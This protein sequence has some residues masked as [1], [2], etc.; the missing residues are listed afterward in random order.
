LKLSEI[1]QQKRDHEVDLS[2]LDASQ[3]SW[4][5]MMDKVRKERNKIVKTMTTLEKRYT[6]QKTEMERD[7]RKK[8]EESQKMINELKTQNESLKKKLE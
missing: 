2:L 7:H 5:T 3:S 1:E 8:T 4:K 6:K